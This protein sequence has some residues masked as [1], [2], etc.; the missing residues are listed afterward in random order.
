MERSTKYKCII[1]FWDWI[2]RLYTKRNIITVV[3]M[4]IAGWII[5]NPMCTNYF[6]H[7]DGVSIGLVY[8]WESEG[9]AFG[10]TGIATIDRLFGNTVSPSLSL[11]VSLI[12]IANASLL[13]L[14]LFDITSVAER[15]V[16]IMII[17]FAPHI[18]SLFTYYY[19]MVAYSLALY[20]NVLA[21]Y[22]FAKITDNS[23]GVWLFIGAC[24]IG[25]SL[26]LYQSYLSI[27]V[28]L[29]MMFLLKLLVEHNTFKDIILFI[30]RSVVGFFV[31]VYGYLFYI[32]LG[33][34]IQLTEGRSF[35]KMGQIDISSIGTLCKGAYY[36]FYEYF[37]G[38]ALLNNSWMYR[39]VINIVIMVVIFIQL[40]Y[41]VI[42]RE[43][44]KEPWRL[45]MVAFILFLFPIGFELSTIIA[46]G[47]E[48][49]GTT[50]ILLVPAMS[51]I[52][53]LPIIWQ[54][55]KINTT[56]Y[57]VILGIPLVALI[58]NLILFTYTF[59]NVMWLNYN[60]AMM[61]CS[62]I[63]DV[64]D[65]EF[66]YESGMK[67]MLAGDAER[68]NYPCQYEHLKD[69]V[70][71]TLAPKGM[72]W[73]GWLQDVCYTNIWRYYQGVEYTYPT[74]DEYAEIISSDEF[75]SMELF[76][77][78]GSL[79]MIDGIVVIKLSE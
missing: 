24:L 10:R 47:V 43:F 8:K 7:G 66:G 58:W 50:G 75:M 19:C 34:H 60:K 73:G 61:L 71:G 21:V 78:E 27:T 64:V 53:I 29:C 62:K 33:G 70:K 26:S 44:F 30:I 4:L 12:L 39:N 76:P 38:N 54:P 20:L 57:R 51:C 45:V 15:I 23:W 13:I 28:V 67:I 9:A 6:T 18:S 17:L 56:L 77:N 68:G 46:P 14:E 11:I 36:N 5:Y 40:I 49:Y 79:K 48:P 2:C 3:G 65:E 72:S 1:V 59:E 55:K 74:S 25:F 41:I 63:S 32:K 31:G 35:D 22:M 37:F 42:K 16:I 69:I 52:Y